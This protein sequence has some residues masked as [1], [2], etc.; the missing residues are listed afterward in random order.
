[1]RILVCGSRDWPGTWEDIA[2]RFPDN[3]RYDVTIIHGAC[4][5]KTRGVQ[6]SVD[7]LADFAARSLGFTA[8]PYPVDHAIDGPWPA[9]GP[10]RNARMLRSSKPDRGL[11]FGAIWKPREPRG[12]YER[13]GARMY[14]LTFWKTTGTGDMVRRM[15]AVRLPVRWISAPDAEPI[16][17]VRMP[18][19][20]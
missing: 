1:V 13:S 4:S 17:L 5:Q 14:K 3:H 19:Y 18:D 11:A 2:I 12:D 15:L 16:D 9:A 10:N 6:T 20:P 8:D 7:M